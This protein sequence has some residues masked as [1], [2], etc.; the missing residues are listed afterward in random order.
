[1]IKIILNCTLKKATVVTESFP[2]ELHM[3]FYKSSYNDFLH[4]AN[5]SDGLTVLSY[6]FEAVE[7]E[8][9]RYDKFEEELVKVQNLGATAEVHDFVPVQQFIIDDKDAY[10]TYLGSLTT[11]PCSEVVI[12]IEFR[13]TVPLSHDQIQTF[14]QLSGTHGRLEHNF[15]P[16]QPLFDRVIYMNSGSYTYIKYTAFLLTILGIMCQ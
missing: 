7:S 16:I 10:F 3:V 11:P 4:A 6:L 12:W 9:H 13:Q 15:R 5:H 1:M 8:N 14:R 2:L